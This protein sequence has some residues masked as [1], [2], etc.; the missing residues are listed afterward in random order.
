MKKKSLDQE[1]KNKIQELYA[2]S[3]E[4]KLL[5]QITYQNSSSEI[6]NCCAKY[7][8][9]KNLWFLKYKELKQYIENYE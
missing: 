7:E 6:D 8:E 3:N 9:L 5:L 4:I 2:I 1:I